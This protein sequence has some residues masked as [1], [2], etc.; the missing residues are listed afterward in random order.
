MFLG[1]AALTTTAALPAQTTGSI[2]FINR[3]PPRELVG[4]IRAWAGSNQV[5]AYNEDVQ[6]HVWRVQF[7]AFL[8]RAPRAAE[9]T[10]VF[11][12]LDGR[13]RR[14]ITNQ[15]VSLTNPND[16]VFFHQTVLHRSPDEFQP[17]ENYEV[18]ITVN[19]ARGATEI[20]RG[21]IGLVG[22]PDRHDG[23]VDFTGGAPVVR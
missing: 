14:Y 19:D 17:M 23:V 13:T 4:N 7:M 20:A 3:R 9:V 1:A 11:Y 15:A 6:S 12:K 5:R 21:R 16:Q 8:A 10:L 18:A 22:T 2:I